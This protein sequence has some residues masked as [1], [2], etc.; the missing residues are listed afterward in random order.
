[1]RVQ[2]NARPPSA[3]WVD[4]TRRLER[5]GLWNGSRS[6]IADLCGR[7]FQAT[8]RFPTCVTARLASVAPA[9]PPTSGH[10]SRRE[11]S[12]QKVRVRSIAASL[13]PASRFTSTSALPA[14]RRFIGSPISGRSTAGLPWGASP[15]RASRPRPSPAGKRADILGLVCHRTRNTSSWVSAPTG[16]R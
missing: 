4:S 7:S 16:A 5:G 1:M 15:I 6:V 10:T 13:T 3:G 14:G 12:G 8:R 2:S 9:R 11:G